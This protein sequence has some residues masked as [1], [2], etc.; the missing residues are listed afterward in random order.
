MRPRNLAAWTTVQLESAQFG[1]SL[2]G[3]AVAGEPLPG[4]NLVGYLRA[5]LGL[6]EI[7]RMIGR[8]LERAGRPYAEIPYDKTVSR[9]EHPFEQRM[10]TE[11]LYDT[12]IICV[13]AD[14]LRGLAE[15]IGTDLFAHRYSIGVWF[16]ETTRFPASEVLAF[17][18]VDEIWVASEFVRDVVSAA[19][20]KPV[21]VVPL[22]LEASLAPALSRADLALPEGVL[23]LFSFDY[24]SVFERKNPLGLVGA[25]R[26]AFAPGEGPVLVIKSINGHRKPRALASLQDAVADRP[27]IQVVDGYVTADEKNAMMASCDCYVSLHRSEGLGLTM[28]EAMSYGKPVIATG[29]SGNTEFMDDDNSFLVPYD[30]REIP[31]GSAYPA[32]AKWAEP[33]LS[34]AAALMR[35]VYDHRDEARECGE[36]G[37]EAILRRFSIERTAEFLTE[38]LSEIRAQRQAAPDPLGDEFKL[39]IMRMARE[40]GKPVGG[41]LAQPGGRSPISIIRRLLVRVLWPSLSEQQR[42]NAAALDAL[43]VLQRSRE[44]QGH[45]SLEFVGAP[46]AANVVPEDATSLPDLAPDV[47]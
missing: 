34:A 19:T 3:L 1:S 23:F 6:G 12:N 8:G 22:P 20:W 29:Y 45:T 24:L 47:S 46:A 35:H 4:V 5:E 17:H 37:R 27:D 39:T 26:E 25:F 42:F 9:Q 36:R 30:L 13:N 21:H 16:W 44:K 11:A 7:A 10:P 14:Q 31:S 32:G 28:A 33:D 43:G 15:D 38:R 41:G 18:F 2:R 40:V